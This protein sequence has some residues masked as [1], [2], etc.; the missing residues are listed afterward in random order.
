MKT[1]HRFREYRAGA[2]KDAV[3]R[4]KRSFVEHSWDDAVDGGVE[5]LASSRQRGEATTT[6]DFVGHYNI[7]TPTIHDL[8][9][10]WWANKRQRKRDRLRN[11]RDL[12]KIIA[13][14]P[15]SYTS[16]SQSLRA[17]R[18]R[19]NAIKITHLHDQYLQVRKLVLG[20]NR[21]ET[22]SWLQYFPNLEILS[23]EA[24]Y[25]QDMH[26]LHWLSK[27]KRLTRVCLAE[28][29]VAFF[30]FYKAHVKTYC[31]QIREVDCSAAM[32]AFQAREEVHFDIST[33]AI[34]VENL[35]ELLSLRLATKLCRV[36]SELLRFTVRYPS[37]SA[38][39][40]DIR[41]NEIRHGWQFRKEAQRTLDDATVERLTSGNLE[42]LLRLWNY[43]E[44][45]AAHELE[46]L[47]GE[48]IR[49]AVASTPAEMF[50]RCG[51]ADGSTAN[52]RWE[53]LAYNSVANRLRRMTAQMVLECDYQREIDQ[54]WLAL[55]PRLG[56]Q[57]AT[58]RAAELEVER[59][60][61]RYS[62]ERAI[63]DDL[64]YIRTKMDDCGRPS[65]LRAS[66]SRPRSPPLYSD[67]GMGLSPL[68]TTPNP[69]IT[70]HR[71][72]RH[73]RPRRS[74]PR[75]SLDDLFDQAYYG[76]AESI[77]DNLA[78]ASEELLRS[79]Y[80]PEGFVEGWGNLAEI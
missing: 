45:L 10:A 77:T 42:T 47:Q 11:P 28:N 6:G 30:P 13:E 32:D 52:E 3:E 73:R 60:Y 20:G 41:L 63:R 38:I 8:E 75:V 68:R 58:R 62:E 2:H 80:T 67:R 14:H 9:F 33:Q 66:R 4:Q 36:H 21:L 70:P 31:P 78:R 50:R 71:S 65:S 17:V 49:E 51:R 55:R 59:A 23:L 16:R 74:S 35:C 40:A 22:M 34:L 43:S 72:E 69:V 19:I 46:A 76:D 39:R 57:T 5:G 54:E 15:E 48:I 1:S 29:P 27:P 25:L 79:T 18:C 64:F 37:I 26:E 12:A 7:A 24:N 53:V 44:H 61:H 56:P